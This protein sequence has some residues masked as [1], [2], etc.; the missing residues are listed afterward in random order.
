MQQIVRKAAVVAALGVGF[1][2]AATVMDAV[3]EPIL[4]ATAQVERIPEGATD[5]ATAFRE[6][7]KA[8]LPAVVYVEVQAAPRAVSSRVPEQ[9][10]GTPFEDFFGGG[11]QGMQMRPQRGSGS[12]FIISRDGYII[13]NNHVVED[14][15]Q[16]TVTLTDKREF[17][18][19][20]VGRDP[21]TDVAVLKVD[22][23]NLPVARF[24]DSS[25]LQIGDWVLA[26]GYRMQ[27]GETVTAGIV[28]AMGRSLGIIERN[29][30]SQ[31]PLEHFIQT[32][33]AINPGNSGGPL[34]N[35]KGEV[36][37]INTAIASQ[38][39][40]YNGYGFAVPVTLAR[41]VADDLMRDGVV[42]RPRLGVPIRGVSLADA[43]VFGLSEPRGAWVAG[44]P[45]GPAAE[46]GIKMG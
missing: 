43:E 46:A 7:S 33:A 31:N 9:F 20:V 12:G 32:D 28:S 19:R 18:A 8:A 26:L 17:D 1:G 34:V 39:G 35:L 5:L 3:Q 27:L 4:P 30:Q 21:N 2:A 14:A 10:R 23:D 42:H 44:P 13:T 45:E 22:G 38:T 29:E 25:D 36:I 24:G 6:A 11:G 40:T 37:G 41:R 15:S 16:V